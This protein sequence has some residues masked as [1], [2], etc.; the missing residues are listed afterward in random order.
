MRSLLAVLLASTAFPSFAD[1][2]SAES[3]VTAVT[4]YPLGAKV[5]RQVTVTIP[6]AGAHEL[7]V[8][9][10]PA[11][12]EAGLMQITAPAGVE[13][14]AFSLRSDRLPPR[15]EPETPAQKA[16]KVEVERLEAAEREAIAAVDNVQ[17]R[18]DAA[19]ARA[20]FLTSFNG[21]LPAN[22]TPESLAAMAAMIG[23]ETLAAKAE[24]AEARKALW[25]AQAALAEVQEDLQTARAALA[26]LP[27]EDTQ[28][29]ALSVALEAEAAGEVTLT[30]THYIQT[31]GWRPYY[32]VNLTRKDGNALTIDR[33]VL[34]TQGTGEDWSGVD[35]VLSSSRPSEQAWPSSLWPELRSIGKEEPPVVYAED[36][37][38]SGGADTAMEIV[39]PM[40][41]PVT[42]EAAMEGD[43]VV[44]V[45]PRKVDVASGVEDL[46]LPL[47]QLNFDPTVEA[48]AVS[49]WDQSA[50]VMARFIN[51]DEPILPGEA[52]FFREGVLVGSAR[53][54]L[55]APGVET[56]L[57]FGALET[58][59]ITRNMPQRA[60]GEKG[61]LTTS[62]L[63]SEEVV[64]KVENLGTEAWPVRLLDLVPYSEQDDLEIETKADPQPSEV[65]VDGQ[66][67][68]LAWDFTLQAGEQKSVTLGYEMTWPEGM[69]LR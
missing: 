67:G 51:G 68:I 1:R 8:T 43:T 31:A 36:M 50:F 44:Y 69:V 54:G 37:A 4:V 61:I 16:V 5:T 13:H 41:A 14:G 17:A 2:L 66:R 56:E 26:S 45:Y 38:R 18:I 35:L 49:R 19:N 48:L 20:G 47:D 15:A 55:T 30:L 27:M 29:T 53:L 52:M 59:R 12:T 7:L 9:D 22:A 32:E 65:D 46:R 57:A 42:A 63:Q 6:S 28:Y 39:V 64:I 10:L 62:N 3:D 33:S 40:P 23:T 25:P 60:G 11:D 24:A 21:D 58:L 34:V